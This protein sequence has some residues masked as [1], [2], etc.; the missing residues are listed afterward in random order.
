MNMLAERLLTMKL[1]GMADAL[2]E[3][4]D[5]TAFKEMELSEQLGMLLEQESIYRQN[6]QLKRLIT[7]AK[8]R[9][10]DACME[11][12][13]FKAG[14]GFNKQQL[15]DLSSTDWIRDK[16]NIIITGA[17][18]TGKT[19][20]ACAIG[21]SACRHGIKTLYIRQP[22]LFQE[23]KISRADG[24]YMKKLDKISKIELL[25]IDDW[26]MSYLNDT[27]RRDLL[28]VAEDRYNIHSTV[29]VTQFPID[30]W[31]SLIGDP[32]LADAICDRLIHNAYKLKLTGESMRKLKM[33]N[34]I[35]GGI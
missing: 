12:I 30:K 26:G 18:G 24:G 25:I 34:K 9:Y 3:Y 28:E 15:I 2:K 20:I 1:Y 16:R 5:S 21:N 22:R 17:T 10:G 7:M 23:L 8:L 4:A 11:E 33:E 32:T 27:E 19:Y 6:K 13:N 14:R 31:H 35:K 29:I